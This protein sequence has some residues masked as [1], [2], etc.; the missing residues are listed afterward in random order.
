MPGVEIALCTEADWAEI[1]MLF[2][3]WSALYP[4]V[5]APGCEVYSGKIDGALIG[6]AGFI[7]HTQGQAYCWAAL[8][9]ERWPRYPRRL[10][11]AIMAHRDEVI[12]A[13]ELVRLEARADCA[14]TAA[15]RFLEVMG[16]HCEGWTLAS[17][18]EGGDQFLYGY[19]TPEWEKRRQAWL[20]QQYGSLAHDV[21]RMRQEYLLT[22]VGRRMENEGKDRRSC[23]DSYNSQF[24]IIHSQLK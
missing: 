20:V 19:L 4:H 14:H 22:Q 11:A 24:S 10:L 6:T 5:F 7:F 9:T 13:H 23:K 21:S 15:C 17:N 18:T 1:V 16:F 12:R 3:V 2:P 8:I